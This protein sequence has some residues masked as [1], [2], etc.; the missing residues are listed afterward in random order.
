MALVMMLGANFALADIV[1]EGTELV[2]VGVNDVFVPKGF[3]DNDEAVA[4][5]DGHLNNSCYRLAHNEVRLDPPQR[6]I[7]VVQYARRFSMLCIQMRIPFWKEASLGVLPIGSYNVISSDQVREVLSISE[8]ENSGPDDHMYAPVNSARVERDE[9]GAYVA[10]VEGEIAE[11]CMKWKELKLVNSG[12]TKELLPI[13]EVENPENCQGEQMYPFKKK[14][15]LPND[16]PG[17]YLLHVR[18]L[19]GKAVNYMYSVE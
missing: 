7:Q 14:V 12:K 3:D 11:S 18:S 5:V 17:R 8:A 1:D 19:N 2:I 13:V 6:E 15:S 9:G 4:V 16:N 10:V